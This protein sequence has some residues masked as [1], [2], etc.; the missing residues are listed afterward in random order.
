[1]AEHAEAERASAKRS[2]EQTLEI[3]APAEAVWRALTEARELENWFPV[4]ARVEPE[5]GGVGSVIWSKWADD[6][7]F[8]APVT[9]WEPARRLRTLWCPP[10]TPEADLFGVDFFLE[11]SGGS[12]TLRLVHFGFGPEHEGNWATMYD[13]VNRGWDFQ[14]FT[15]KH[16]LEEH[17]GSAREVV[18]VR[19]DLSDAGDTRSAWDAVLSA[20]GLVRGDSLGTCAEGDA[21]SAELASGERMTGV[22]R[23]HRPGED[24]QLVIESMNKAY[25]RVQIDPCGHSAGMHLSVLLGAWGLG[26]DR[27]REMAARWSADLERLL[28]GCPVLSVHPSQ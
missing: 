18:Q 12:T 26:A 22:V 11:E 3:G 6:L 4:E 17:L 28:P 10:E 21:F 9:I 15:L 25:M 16:F 13:G 5:A 24:L 20:T 8:P 19:C 14:L 23:R 27:Q 1:M 7:E 2:I